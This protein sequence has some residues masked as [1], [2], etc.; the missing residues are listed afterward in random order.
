MATIG[1]LEPFTTYSCFVFTQVNGNR[2]NSTETITRQ[3]A[4]EGMGC[5]EN[6]KLL[7]LSVYYSLLH[8]DSLVYDS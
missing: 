3:T 7:R 6:T 4:E 1:G 5:Y 2:G 8:A